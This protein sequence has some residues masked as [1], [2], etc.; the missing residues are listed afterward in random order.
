MIL[1]IINLCV[2]ETVNSKTEDWF[3]N[4]NITHALG[5]TISCN[6]YE[7][8]VI[9]INKIIIPQTFEVNHHYWY[10]QIRLLEAYR[11]IQILQDN[12]SIRNGP[13]VADYSIKQSGAF[14]E[15]IEY[16]P[17]VPK[18]FNNLHFHILFPFAKRPEV[19]SLIGYKKNP[20]F[21]ITIQYS[22]IKISSHPEMER[23]ISKSV[24]IDSK[25]FNNFYTSNTLNN[26]RC[27][28]ID[29]IDTSFEKGR[30]YTRIN[31][32]TMPGLLD[33]N[34]ML[35][36]E[37]INISIVITKDRAVAGEYDEYSDQTDHIQVMQDIINLV[38]PFR[39][40][41]ENFSLMLQ[42]E[43]TTF[44][45]S[46][47]IP[48]FYKKDINNTIN[49]MRDLREQIHRQLEPLFIS[50]YIE[51]AN[52]HFRN[53]GGGDITISFSGLNL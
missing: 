37:K 23:A 48:L 19:N 12:I 22:L 52:I 29:P 18:I 28:L 15:F 39:D 20:T 2:S 32:I 40:E 30:P 24:I 42:D 21:S 27:D 41:I 46:M 33:F 13:V 10:L 53:R 45:L 16:Y 26:F 38:E 7:H 44:K 34:S 5:Q 51:E 17:L 35:C 9:G 47:T 50:V 3:K 36:D 43:E 8:W 1:D 49:D 6:A 31:S 14:R 11:P 4:L 25:H